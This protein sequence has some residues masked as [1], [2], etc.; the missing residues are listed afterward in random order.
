M[1]CC[2]PKLAT[3][4]ISA[5][6]GRST[7]LKHLVS[8]PCV[9][10]R[11]LHPAFY[12]NKIYPKSLYSAPV[13]GLHRGLMYYYR[14]YLLCKLLLAFKASWPSSLKPGNLKPKAATFGAEVHAH[15]R[16]LNRGSGTVLEDPILHPSFRAFPPKYPK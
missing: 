12:P 1:P 10:Q 13:R 14:G 11:F 8:G 6:G 3:T 9:V 2:H 5:D 15:Q 7:P 4:G 16:Y